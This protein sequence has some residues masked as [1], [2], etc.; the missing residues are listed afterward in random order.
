[1]HH[2]RRAVVSG[3][4]EDLLR[5]AGENILPRKENSKRRAESGRTVSMTQDSELIVETSPEVL[6]F[7]FPEFW[8][9]LI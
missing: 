2:V 4:K 1:M 8:Y 6:I 5:I 9:E 7:A 3:K